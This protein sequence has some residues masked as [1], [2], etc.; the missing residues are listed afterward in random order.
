MLLKPVTSKLSWFHGV[1]SSSDSEGE[2]GIKVIDWIWL[3][4]HEPNGRE[5]RESAREG[6][7]EPVNETAREGTREPVNETAREGTREPVNKEEQC[8][9]QA[10]AK[11][12]RSNSV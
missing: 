3:M 8:Q 1:N 4:K 12:S 5:E 6:T 11:S 7:R 9:Q 10:K 2:V